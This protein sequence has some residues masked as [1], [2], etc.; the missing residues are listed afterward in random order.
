MF[1]KDKALNRELND[2]IREVVQNGGSIYLV[3]KNHPEYSIRLTEEVKIVYFVPMYSS[4]SGKSYRIE[5][6]NI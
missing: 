2:L 4:K 5:E 3:N 6:A 1:E